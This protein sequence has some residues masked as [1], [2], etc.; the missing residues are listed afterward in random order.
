[1]LRTFILSPPLPPPPLSLYLCLSLFVSLSL[2]HSV[3]LLI[4]PSF[5]HSVSLYA[6]YMFPLCL[7]VSFSFCSLSLSL[8][9][10]FYWQTFGRGTFCRQTIGQNSVNSPYLWPNQSVNHVRRPDGFRLK[11]T[12][13]RTIHF[14]RQVFVRQ[15]FNQQAYVWSRG[16]NV[17]TQLLSC[18]FV[19]HRLVDKFITHWVDEMS[20][21]QKFIGEKTRDRV[22]HLQMLRWRSEWGEENETLIKY[23]CIFGWVRVGVGVR[24]GK[25]KRDRYIDR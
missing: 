11:Y 17:S 13:P 3:S 6:F 7:S 10:P 2:F 23:A 19:D 1:M 9:L 18:H 5:F 8:S 4:R 16:R 22:K 21:G 12:E 24:K 20:V 25:T 14:R 15:T